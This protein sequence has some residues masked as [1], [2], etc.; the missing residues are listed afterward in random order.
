MPN[1]E[2]TQ[3]V[4]D[5]IL[6]LSAA[7]MASKHL[8]VA[9]DLGL[10]EILADG[11]KTLEE[12]RSR[13][14]LPVRNV[15]VLAD[16][17]TALGL[18]IHSGDRYE[19]SP[20]ATAYLGGNAGTGLRP[21]LRFW[22]RIAYPRWTRLEEAIRSGKPVFG[23]LKFTEEEQEIFSEGVESITRDCAL[24]LASH[25]DFG[26][27]QRILDLGGG[28]GSFLIALLERFPN[29][30]ATL[31]E[32]PPVVP[33]ARKKL[34]NDSVYPKIRIVQGDFFKDPI[35]E[36]HDAVLIANVMH[37]FSPEQNVRLLRTLRRRVP[38]KTRL[39]IIDFWTDHS[40]TKPLF[41]AM[42]VGE[43][44]LYTGVG[45]VYSTEQVCDWLVRTGWQPLENSMLIYPETLIVSESI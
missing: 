17:M 24:A 28:T 9:S 20:E 16:A 33:M 44:L 21:F 37:S 22:N 18:C 27:H 23:G 7:F 41:A 25:Y 8:F 29:L 34:E 30:E 10:F 39:L 31:F 35:P 6:D 2:N 32:T 26:R 13:I 40:R 3:V 12:I 4:S 15:R 19:N 5:R 1:Q 43:F 42:I 38:Q 36:N 14:K 11:P 45:D